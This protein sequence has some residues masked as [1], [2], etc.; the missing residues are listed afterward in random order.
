MTFGA[1]LGLR[2]WHFFQTKTVGTFG[3]YLIYTAIARHAHYRA[4]HEVLLR[5]HKFI[6][7]GMDLVW[8]IF[9]IKSRPWC[10]EV[11]HVP[12]TTSR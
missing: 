2:A 12:D 6:D 11:I 4:E 10:H 7:D 1:P 9:V 5:V 8:N 3:K